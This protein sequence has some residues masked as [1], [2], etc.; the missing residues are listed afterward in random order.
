M[1]E[2]G[3]LNHSKQ[4]G[5]TMSAI[6]K[7][8][9]TL[10]DVFG[11]SDFRP[12]QQAILEAVLAGHDVLAIMPTGGGKSLCYQLPALLNEG[13]TLVVSP[14]ISLMKDQVDS[15]QALGIPATFINSSL[16]ENEL[17]SRLSAL[18]AGTYRLVFVAPE[19]FASNRFMERIT[20][21]P[22]SLLAVDEAHCISWWGHDFRP[23]Y[24][25]L[26][27][28][29]ERLAGVQTIALTA[30]ATRQVQD[31]I[32]AQLGMQQAKVFVAGFDRPNLFLQV[33]RTQDRM[34]GVIN[35]IQQHPGMGIVYAGTRKNVEQV[36]E[37]LKMAGIAALPYH[38]GLADAVRKK[39][40]DDFIHERTRVIVATN[41]FGMGID[42]PNIR[43]VLH[44][45]MPGSIEGYYQEAG[46]AGRDGD[47]ADCILFYS[48]ED[49]FLR[50]RLIEL[51][52]PSLEII[53]ET[54]AQ[55]EKLQPEDIQPISVTAEELAMGFAGKVHPR[56]VDSALKFLVH[57]GYLGFMT[58]S[59]QE[60]L[61]SRPRE[62]SIGQMGEAAGFAEQL[63]ALFDQQALWLRTSSSE[64]ADQFETDPARIT[65]LLLDVQQKGL[66][67]VL[68]PFARRGYVFLKKSAPA[69]WKNYLQERR[70]DARKRLDDMVAYCQSSE[71]RH[72]FFVRYFGEKVVQEQCE[73]C[74]NCTRELIASQENTVLTQKILSCVVRMGESFGI[75][76]VAE[77]LNGSRSKRALRFQ[78]LPT[79]GLLAETGIDTLKQHI[80]AVQSAGYLQLTPGEY[81][82]LKVTERGWQVLRGQAEAEL[83]E[84]STERKRVSAE[85]ARVDHQLFDELRRVRMR[86]ARSRDVPPYVIF[87]DRTLREMAT[88]FPKTEADFR[89]ISG[90]GEVK[91]QAF[92]PHFQRVIQAYLTRH[93][94][95]A[96]DPSGGAFFDE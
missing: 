46:R 57:T 70:R 36:C 93:R 94:R 16:G 84:L 47:P 35:Y 29:R 66:C 65:A 9:R 12:G 8:R 60:L 68:G 2:K 28:A 56:F 54:W 67:R 78:K 44:F 92:V 24:T 14:L 58:G 87:P 52:N 3:H 48:P 18:S 85:D 15:L 11:F 86:L 26:R 40:Q 72:A 31:D 89:E 53:L 96:G 80:R 49:R 64:L 77:V 79:Y 37:S 59:R 81:P 95:E 23:A 82:V 10:S 39:V 62:E 25:R 74:D 19:R 43:F 42:K 33:D 51:S 50:E 55:L 5:K 38:A 73:A 90:I 69:S 32:L 71:C 7:A 6:E 88:F 76:A 27:R 83:P 13:I 22:L 17:N 4:T 20:A 30:T 41:A 75:V 63:M 91:M 1:I 21:L 45:Q 34:E 61:I